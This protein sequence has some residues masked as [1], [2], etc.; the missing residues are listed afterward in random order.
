MIVELHHKFH[1]EAI[2]GID[3]HLEAF[4]K[5]LLIV[6]KAAASVF[7]QEEW[8]IYRNTQRFY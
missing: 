1:E 3:L 6:D 5:T 7:T 8:I 2:S 4:H